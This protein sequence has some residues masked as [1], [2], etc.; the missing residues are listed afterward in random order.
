MDPFGMGRG[1]DMDYLEKIELSSLER[2][3]EFE[4]ICR[5]IDDL[6]IEDAKLMAKCYAKLY[7]SNLEG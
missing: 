1:V 6:T 7:I 3:F 4:K 2:T 5:V